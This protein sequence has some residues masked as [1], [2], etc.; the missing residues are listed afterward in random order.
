MYET[1]KTL[2]HK[3]FRAEAE[4]R[5]KTF[6]SDTYAVQPIDL[7]VHELLVCRI[8]LGLQNEELRRAQIALEEAR[9]RYIDLY[10]FAPIAYVSI[11]SS[12]EI[13]EINLTGASMFQVDRAKLINQR[14]SLFIDDSDKRRWHRL[15]IYMMKHSK[16]LQH[17]FNLKMIRLNN[18]KFCTHVSCVLRKASD[19][20]PAILRIALIDTSK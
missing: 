2:G 11:S 12:G 14:F 4:A 3:N 6:F 17:E 9:N 13:S 16:G 5:A 18:S 20:E 15:F 10:E 7:L 19:N 1:D 8:E